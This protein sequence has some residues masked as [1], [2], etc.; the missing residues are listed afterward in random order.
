MKATAMNVESLGKPAFLADVKYGDF[1]FAQI[2]ETIR[3]CVKSYL[4]ENDAHIVD[5]VI[6]LTPGYQDESKLP[7]LIES[8]SV[9]GNTAYRISDPVFRPTVSTNTMLLR[10]EYWPKPGMVVENLDGSFLTIKNG[11]RSHKIVYMN[12]N[13][14]ELVLSAPKAPFVFIKEWRMVLKRGDTEQVLVQFPFSS[15]T[16]FA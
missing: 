10:P 1:F 13:T 5:S 4:I 15:E 3:G 11:N 16:V 8:K 12:L 6:A 2:G 9:V 14:G 7:L